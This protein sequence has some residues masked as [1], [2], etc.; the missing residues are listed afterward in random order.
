MAVDEN[1]M[2]L[3][4]DLVVSDSVLADFHDAAKRQ[5]LMKDRGLS[6]EAIT[7]INDK[8]GNEVE[9]L[10]NTQVAGTTGRRGG[11]ATKTKTGGRKKAGKKR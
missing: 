8:D 1:L 3:I 4:V 9:R 7:A 6:T 5:Q 10:L 2:D 11:A